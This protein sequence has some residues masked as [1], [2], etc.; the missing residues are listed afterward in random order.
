M[1]EISAWRRNLPKQPGIICYQEL[2]QPQTESVAGSFPPNF[3]SEYAPGVTVNGMTIGEQT[4]YDSSKLSL[5]S[6]RAVDLGLHPLEKMIRHSGQRS[7]LL[8]TFEIEGHEFMVANI[9]LAWF[10]THGRR[11]KQLGAVIDAMDPGKPALIVGDFNYTNKIS[12]RGLAKF[13]EEYDFYPAGERLTTHRFFGIEHQ[14]DYV[15]QRNC[16]VLEIRAGNIDLSDHA[17]IFV[18]FGVGQNP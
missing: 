15:F 7:A 3:R 12:A 14:V 8:T 13:L 11:R 5:V 4:I 17:P 10:T 6:S 2:P 18:T 16:T 1:D 9:H